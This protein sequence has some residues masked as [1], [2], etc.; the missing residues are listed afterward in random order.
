MNKKEYKKI[1]YL[2]NKEKFLEQSR[3]KYEEKRAEHKRRKYNN[4]NI[5]ASDKKDYAKKY[6]QIK[7]KPRS[8][9]AIRG[10]VLKPK[11]ITIKYGSLTVEL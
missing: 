11:P 9:Q 5:I 1:Y 7:N 4:T 8:S 6:Y 2:K 3:K 10:I